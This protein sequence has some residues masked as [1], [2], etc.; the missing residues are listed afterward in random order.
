MKKSRTRAKIKKA[1]GQAAFPRRKQHADDFGSSRKI[2]GFS[3]SEQN[4]EEN[5]D[6]QTMCKARKALQ[7][8]DQSVNAP[9]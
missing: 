6:A 4:A 3:D 7:A 9:R 1:R 2:N 5:Q 8:S